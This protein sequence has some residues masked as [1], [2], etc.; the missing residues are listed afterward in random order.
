[1]GKPNVRYVAKSEEGKG[2]RVWD[3][4]L[5][6]WWGEWR[7]E[8]PDAVLRE[9]NGQARPEVLVELCRKR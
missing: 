3:R 6:R 9:L 2:W 4:T 1:M 5:R 7:K 8:Y